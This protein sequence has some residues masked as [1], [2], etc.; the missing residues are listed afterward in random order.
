MLL[1]TAEVDLE[2][3]VDL[4]RR[5][6]LLERLDRSS[7][8]PPNEYAA[9]NRLRP[10]PGM[11]HDE[12]ARERHEHAGVRRS[13]RRAG[14]SSRRSGRSADLLIGPV[15]LRLGRRLVRAAG[16]RSRSAD[17]SR[18]VPAGP[19]SGT[20][21][22]CAPSCSRANSRLP[23]ALADTNATRRDDADRDERDREATEKGKYRRG[24][25]HATQECTD[26]KCRFTD[27]PT[28][29]TRPSRSRRTTRFTP[30]VNPSPGR[31]RG[32]GSR[33]FPHRSRGSW[34]RGRSD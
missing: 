28:A 10:W 29:F 3:V 23:Y 19:T 14:P 8:G 33:S 20:C 13:D 30:Q 16:R 32:A 22:R 25:G 26:A 1:E 17:S 18:A 11:L 15:G 31:A 2:V 7:V 12:V 9:F 27:A 34:R 6:V 4:Q 24:R 21:R 5:E